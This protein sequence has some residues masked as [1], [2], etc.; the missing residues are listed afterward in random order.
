[1][2]DIP[3]GYQFKEVRSGKQN[4]VDVIVFRYEKSDLLNNGLE[5]EHYS[6]TIEQESHK[7]VGIT[8]MDQRLLPINNFHL[9]K[10]RGTCKRVTE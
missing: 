7:I 10:D 6:F 4:E 8:W 2:I 1:M 5:G 9:K 3:E